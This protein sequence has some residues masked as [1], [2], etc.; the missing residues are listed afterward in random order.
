MPDH[1][2]LLGL[3][4]N[5]DQKNGMSFLR[6][7]LEPLLS[8]RRFQPQA[9]DHVLRE[10]E[11]RRGAFAKICFYILDN[12][13]RA[14]LVDRPLA[15]TYSGAML[16]GYPTLQPLDA[17]FWPMFWKIH[18]TTRQPGTGERKLP[19]RCSQSPPERS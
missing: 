5:T 6:T 7:H 9:Y 15:W 14:R 19:L 8:P 3:R 16:P 11:R 17:N 1:L 10:E 4:C 13:V 12:P 2:H 18:Q